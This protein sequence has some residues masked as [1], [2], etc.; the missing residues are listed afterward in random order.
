MNDRRV[1][2][3]FLLLLVFV[4]HFTLTIVDSLREY[5]TLQAVQV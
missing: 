5:L 1:V 2:K 4:K 3:P